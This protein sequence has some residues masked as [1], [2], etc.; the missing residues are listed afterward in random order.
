MLQFVLPSKISPLEAVEV[1]GQAGNAAGQCHSLVLPLELFT[2]L[3]ALKR[4]ISLPTPSIGN[5]GFS[6]GLNN[7]SNRENEA[8]SNMN[9]TTSLKKSKSKNTMEQLVM[10]QQFDGSWLLHE[11]LAMSLGIPEAGIES[12]MPSSISSASMKEMHLG[13]DN[14]R[15]RP[16]DPCFKQ[17]KEDWELIVQ[18]ATQS[19]EKTLHLEDERDGFFAHAKKLL[20]DSNFFWKINKYILSF[21]PNP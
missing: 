5:A 15:L 12:A 9:A 1:G 7:N 21:A 2:F 13:H 19:I 11:K 10:E 16:S 20:N 8:N 18:K 3:G 17:Y 6:S 14:R 4:F